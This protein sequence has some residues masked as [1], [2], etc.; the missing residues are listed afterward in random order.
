[1]QNLSIQITGKIHHIGETQVVSGTFQK[2]DLVVECVGDNPAYPQ[3]ISAQF[4]Q[5]KTQLLDG[6][7][8]GQDVTLSIDLR[9]REWRAPSGELRYFNTLQAWRIESAGEAAQTPPSDTQDRSTILT[10]SDGLPF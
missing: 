1:M 8:V 3:L 5:D 7:Q 6:Y 2:R 9:G 10:S 4:V